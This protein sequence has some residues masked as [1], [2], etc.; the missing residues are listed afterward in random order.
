M[1]RKI[2]IVIIAII[3][4][5]VS[6]SFAKPEY[7]RLAVKEYVDRMQAGW[8]GQ[9]AGVGMGAP[10]EFIALGGIVPEE[11]IELVKDVWCTREGEILEAQINL[12][13]AKV[14]Y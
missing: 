4:F 1:R 12:Q 7:R 10:C 2:S 13:K 8:L 9:M 3:Y 11:K 14:V 5:N 6:F